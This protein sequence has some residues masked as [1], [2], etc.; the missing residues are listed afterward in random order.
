VAAQSGD[1]VILPKSA[2]YDRPTA[3]AVH[4]ARHNLVYIH[5]LTSE[6]DDRYRSSGGLVIVHIFS[7]CI[8]CR[9]ERR[10]YISI[11]FIFEYNFR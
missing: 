8:Y 5:G 9:Q 6:S 4:S 7:Y 2:E 1:Y 11:K 10:V 3:K